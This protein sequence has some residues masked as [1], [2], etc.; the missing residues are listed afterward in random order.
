MSTLVRDAALVAGKDLR[1]EL[2]SRVTTNQV[3]PFALLVLLLFGFALDADRPVLDRTTPGLFWM[4]VLFCTVLAVQ[5]SFALEAADGNRDALRL[6][7]LQPAG[8]LLGKGLAVA[9]QLLLLQVVLLLGV[10]LLYGTDLETPLLLLATCLAAT[11]GLAAAGTLFGALAAGLRVRDT[12]L[13]LL[14]LPMLAPVLIAATRAFED[15]LG[16][17]G[18]NGWAWVNLLL[19]FAV[20]YATLTLACASSLLEEP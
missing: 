5:R 18:V 17:V 6:S 7:G 11:V 2:R 12:L 8:I 16:T 13:P 1:L 19:V 3:A 9:G 10:A 4:A 15:A 14:L 20:A